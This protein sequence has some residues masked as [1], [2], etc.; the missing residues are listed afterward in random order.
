MWLSD[1]ARRQGVAGLAVARSVLHRRPVR[2]V[3][4]LALLAPVSAGAA[5]SLRGGGCSDWRSSTPGYWASACVTRPSTTY[6]SHAR[7]SLAAGHGACTIA[8]GVAQPATTSSPARSRWTYTACP[9]GAAS[10]LRITGPALSGG[11]NATAAVRIYAGTSIK[12]TATS[13][14]AW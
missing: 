7:I 12:A 3:L 13:P 1:H 2:G 5:E 10:D 4:F 8:I 14:V 6:L 9:S 11:S